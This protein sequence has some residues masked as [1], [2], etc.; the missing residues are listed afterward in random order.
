MILQLKNS[1][2]K[3]MKITLKTEKRYYSF[4]T[5]KKLAGLM[6]VLMF[7]FGISSCKIKSESKNTSTKLVVPDWSLPSFATHKQIPA[8]VDFHM[9]TKT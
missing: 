7:A 5:L 1:L 2:K 6:V 3:E 9:A 4:F 8:P